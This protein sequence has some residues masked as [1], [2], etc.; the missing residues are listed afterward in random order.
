[1]VLK[2][3]RTPLFT[4]T[5][6]IAALFAGNELVALLLR[7]D[8]S[9]ASF[10]SVTQVLLL[11]MPYLLSYTLPAG[12]AI[13]ASLAITRLA[14]ENEVTAMRSAGIPIRRI[15][16][17]VLCVGLL[18]SGL[19]YWLNENVVPE[20]MRRH[21]QL[22]SDLIRVQASPTFAQNVVT[23]FDKYFARFG[24]VS[25][26][27]DGGVDL[28]DV[29]IFESIKSGEILLYQAPSA[30]YL[31]GIWKLNSPTMHH[32]SDKDMT[33]I[34]SDSQISIDESIQI[35]NLLD[36]P[37]MVE[38]TAASLW[39]RI[40]AS[41][42]AGSDPRPLETE[43]YSRYSRPASCFILAGL[44]FLLTLRMAKGATFLGL[45]ISISFV[46]L[47]LYGEVVALQVIAPRAILPPPAAVW[48]PNFIYLLLGIY[49]M[50]RLE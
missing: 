17:P 5:I 13:G 44:S 24:T 38:D 36:P 33:M 7:A 19:S 12:M 46:A 25:K 30:V 26:R 10:T 41:R 8:L 47:H 4:G 40:E 29:F 48:A 49:L 1:M 14:R 39:K 18:L 23:Q 22:M 50:W 20:S 34:R 31:D 43:F 3:L 32:I 15:M 16:I 27:T 42:T 9:R 28:T 35:G 11:R 6:I 2:D 37:A 21:G 45:M